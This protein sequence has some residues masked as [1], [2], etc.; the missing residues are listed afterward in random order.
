MMLR[1]GKNPNH[2]LTEFN[3]DW[4]WILLLTEKQ[5][6]LQHIVMEFEHDNLICLNITLWRISLV[7]LVIEGKFQS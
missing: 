4:V 6:I 7:I 1:T 2:C 3:N 5:T